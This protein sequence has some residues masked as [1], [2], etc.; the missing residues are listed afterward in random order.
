MFRPAVVHQRVD[1]NMELGLKIR[2][3]LKQ[4]ILIRWM[5]DGEIKVF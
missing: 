2:Q 3:I 4:C 5:I 1:L